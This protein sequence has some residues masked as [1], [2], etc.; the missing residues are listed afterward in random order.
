MAPSCDLQFE[1]LAVTDWQISEW[2]LPSRPTKK[3]D[4][5]AKGFSTE[6]VELDAIHPDELR[7][8]VQDAIDRHIDQ[9]ELRVLKVAEESERE[10]L[11]GLAA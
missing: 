3:S 7:R 5:R 10:L 9:D 6:S 11:K 8:L 2:N 4:P 1:Q